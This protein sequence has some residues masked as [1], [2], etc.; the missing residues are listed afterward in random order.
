MTPGPPFSLQGLTFSVLGSTGTHLWDHP[1]APER[2]FGTTLAHLRNQTPKNRKQITFLGSVLGPK[3]NDISCFFL[4]LFLQAFR[5]KEMRSKCR[6][7]CRKR[8]QKLHLLTII[9]KLRNSVSTAP[10]RADRGS[11]LP[12]TVNKLTKKDMRTKTPHAHDV[13]WNPTRKLVK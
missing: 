8:M 3:L 13:L 4:P 10:A 7:I 1:G 5:A 6:K 11:R 2:P 12:E 9:L